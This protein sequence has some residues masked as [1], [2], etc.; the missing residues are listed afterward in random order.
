MMNT[1]INFGDYLESPILKSAEENAKKADIVFCL[2]STLM[3]TP[4][5]SL[6]EMGRKPIRLVICNR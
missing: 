3:V 6:V 1:I 5:S 4:A 2:G